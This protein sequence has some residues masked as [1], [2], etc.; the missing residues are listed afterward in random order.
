MQILRRRQ[1][2]ILLS[3]GVT[4]AAGVLH[5]SPAVAATSCNNRAVAADVYLINATGLSCASAMTIAK[6]WLA[7]SGYTFGLDDPP[8]DGEVAR[9][10]SYRCV[11]RDLKPGTT[12]LRSRTACTS[13][14]KAVRIGLGSGGRQEGRS[15]PLSDREITGLGPTYV[16]NLRVR[17][18]TCSEAKKVVKAFHSCRY[19]KGGVSG[20]C[21][22]KVLGY[23]CSERPRAKN[24]VEYQGYAT[25][26]RGSKRVW[27][28]YQQHTFG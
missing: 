17:G 13:G 19:A 5:A 27:H 15:C 25:C 7:A 26:A 24:P 8:A 21:T 23:T 4:L 6:R 22:T 1:L 12:A 14:R 28:N 9:V 3:A 20:Y 10:G 11:H 16:T 2:K 18:T